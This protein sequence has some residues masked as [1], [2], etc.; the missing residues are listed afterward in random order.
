MGSSD[1]GQIFTLQS[2]VSDDL[3]P[4]SHTQN[5]S[6]SKKNQQHK[7]NKNVRICMN[8]LMLSRCSLN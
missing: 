3:T 7:M 2:E 1:L 8:F 5:A 6:S 4:I